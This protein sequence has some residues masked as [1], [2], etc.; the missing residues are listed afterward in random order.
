MVGVT[1]ETGNAHYSG[2]PLFT[3]QWRVHVFPFLFT[4]FAYVWTSVLFVNDL[5][6]VALIW[7]DFAV[8]E[9]LLA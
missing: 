9:Y 4:D 8:N 2:A 7:T 1:R 6:L 3:L 5:I